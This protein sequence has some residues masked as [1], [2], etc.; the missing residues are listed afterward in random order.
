VS[1]PADPGC[2][3]GFKGGA[4]AANQAAWFHAD[5]AQGGPCSHDAEGPNGHPGT[6]TVIVTSTQ[7]RCE[8]HYAGTN[9]GDGDPAQCVRK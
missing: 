5:K 4:P 2:A 6:V 9:T 1:I 7:W 8:A 3:S